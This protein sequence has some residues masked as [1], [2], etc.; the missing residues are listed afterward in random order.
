[1]RII[2]AHKE[3]NSEDM[4]LG[5]LLYGYY[6]YH[7]ERLKDIVPSDI[8]WNYTRNIT[9]T[10][11]TSL[12][13][14]AT[15]ILKDTQLPRYKVYYPNLKIASSICFYGIDKNANDWHCDN[16]E[17]IKIQALCYQVNFDITDGG[18][19]QIKT[20]D[21]EEVQYYPKNGDVVLMNHHSSE[22]IHRV[23]EIKT[24]KK[25]IVINMVMQ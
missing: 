13:P 17:N 5:L 25:R 21:G 11:N 18:S 8:E 14:S 19:L 3:F 7:D 1:M 16:S 23:D 20:F 4:H 22:L 15:K 10:Y 2:E 12:C 9:E 24:D 6:C